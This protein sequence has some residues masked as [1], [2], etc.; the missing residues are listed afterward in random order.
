MELNKNERK[1]PFSEA[2][3]MIESSS[4]AEFVKGESSLVFCQNQKGKVSK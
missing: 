1:I 4:E 2:W 3:W